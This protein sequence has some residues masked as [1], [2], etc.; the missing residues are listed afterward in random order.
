MLHDDSYIGRNRRIQVSVSRGAEAIP[1]RLES[2]SQVDDCQEKSIIVAMELGLKR[3]EEAAGI[4]TAYVSSRRRRRRRLLSSPW[5]GIELTRANTA[6]AVNA[7]LRDR[8]FAAA[9]EFVKPWVSEK[10][11]K[12]A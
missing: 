8:V 4:A 3:N 12:Q 9:L 7:A 11:P 5:R 10:L 6:A 1:K 2:R